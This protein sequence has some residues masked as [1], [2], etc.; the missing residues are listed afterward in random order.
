MGSRLVALAVVAEAAKAELESADAELEKAKVVLEGHLEFL[1]PG[2]ELASS[3][4]SLSCYLAHHAWIPGDDN[5]NYY[6][7]E[8]TLVDVYGFN[9]QSGQLTAG[10]IWIASTGD[11]HPIPDNGIQIG[12]HRISFSLPLKET[13]MS[14]SNYRETLAARA[15]RGRHGHPRARHESHG[16]A[17]PESLAART[18]VDAVAMPMLAAPAR[19]PWSRTCSSKQ[20]VAAEARTHE[21][22][23]HAKGSPDKGC[24]NTV[25]PGFQKTLSS[26]A[27]GDVI[28]PVSS[29]NDTKQYITVRV[30]K[31]YHMFLLKTSGNWHVHCGLN[32]SPKPVGYFPKSLLP[33][34]IDRPV[35]LRFGGYAARKK[36]AP[37]PPMGNGYV[38]LSSTA[39]LVSNLK[40]IDADGNDHI[41]NTGLPFYITSEECYPLS[42]VDSSRF[43][44]GGPKK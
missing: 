4:D 24:F 7:V 22:T 10:G 23:S 1:Q 26:I 40:L 3:R 16:R 27:P 43:F 39:A 18:V 29:T 34:M 33:A 42:T 8:A 13:L 38:P 25:C 21:E 36:P 12:W 44:Y 5:N 30:F 41:V 17:R 32:G 37:N 28:N 11:G 31:N 6:G 9:L 20:Q 15:V 35:L 14:A 2:V 19:R